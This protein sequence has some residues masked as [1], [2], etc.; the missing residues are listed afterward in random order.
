MRRTV[1]GFVA[2]GAATLFA[3]VVGFFVLAVIARRLGPSGLGA[4]SFALTLTGY[5]AIPANFG[6]TALA[7]RELAQNPERMKPLLG[8]V[9]A[10]Q[11]ALSLVPYL[12][13]VAF[14]PVLAADD[15]SREL[16]PIV[17]LS[18]IVE[19][20]SLGWVVFARQRF[21]VAA[22]GR[23]TGAVTFAVL[24]VLFVQEG[25][26]VAL[27][28]IHLAGIG[29]TSVVT[30]L[31]V[32]RM[33]GRPALGVEPRALVRRFRAGIP[34]G[35]SGVMIAIYY[36]ADSLMLGYLKSVDDVGQYAV[37][38]KIPLAVLA[39]AA[40][41][42]TVLFPH[43]SALAKRSTVELREQV[44]YFGSLALVASLPMLAGAIIVGDQLIPGLFGAEYEPAA[45]PFVVL[46]GAAALVVFTV[47][48]GTAAVALGDERH[49]A[50]AVSLG[51]GLNVLANLVTIPLFGMTGAAAAT[52]G[53]ELVVFAYVLVRVRRLAGWAPLDA[54]RIGRAAAATAA[55]VL[56]LVLLVPGDWTAGLKVAIGVAVFGA[57]ALPLRIVQPAEVRALWA[58]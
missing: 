44:S 38:Y 48:W 22:I 29:A 56:V 37:A 16:I 5:F 47:N 12:L 50:I 45:T 1:T 9:A 46:M 26:T 20:A 42:G 28:W 43:A 21:A 10:L 15:A 55:M 18:F 25:D 40:L 54:D 11:A 58:R 52:L 17:G 14:A 7:T 27:S 19:A 13:L 33:A 35:I 2:L 49:Y 6:V 32:L 51:A 4:F 53:A 8:E 34:L 36:T 24:V 39:F 23:A 57:C 30:A 31:A 3:Q 41:W